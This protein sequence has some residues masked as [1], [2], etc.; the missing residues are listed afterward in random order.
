MKALV[1]VVVPD[2]KVATTNRS[3]LCYATKLENEKDVDDYVAAIKDKLMDMLNGN[4]VLHI[5]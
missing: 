3:N 4:D 5:I 2:K 1:V